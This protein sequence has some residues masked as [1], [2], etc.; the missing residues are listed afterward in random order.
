MFAFAGIIFGIRSRVGVR[1]E[2]DSVPNVERKISAIA[3]R[4]GQLRVYWLGLEINVL[5]TGDRVS[6]EVPKPLM[7]ES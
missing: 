3:C 1:P 7:D 6:D 4:R 2:R 5:R